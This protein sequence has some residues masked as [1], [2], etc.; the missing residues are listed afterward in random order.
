MLLTW[1]KTNIKKSYVINRTFTKLSADQSEKKKK[2]N[3]LT[4]FCLD[5]NFL[6]EYC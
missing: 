2:Q 6:F 4:F 5:L 3:K 1:K